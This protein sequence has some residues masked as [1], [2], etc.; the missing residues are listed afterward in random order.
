MNNINR[1][2]HHFAAVPLK[3]TA[4]LRGGSMLVLAL[5]CTLSV[6]Q[7]SANPPPSAR[8]SLADCLEGATKNAPRG[9][10]REFLQQQ[11]AL[12]ERNIRT[13]WFPALDLNGKASYQSDVVTLE[14]DNPQFPLSLPEMP[15]DQY[16]I[17]LDVRQTLYDGGLTKLSG[18]YEQQKTAAEIQQV[19]V[20]TYSIRDQVS[21]LYFAI[22]TAQEN[23]NNLE[24]TLSN[25]K[26]REAALIA[27]LEH[28]A[29]M[30]KDLKVIRVEILKIL[31]ALSD[32]D[33]SKN[34]ALEMLSVYTGLTITTDITLEKPF[35]EMDAEGQGR[36]PEL[37][38]FDLRE[39]TLLTAKELSGAKR[40]PVV[41]AFGQAGY[42]RPGYNMLSTEFD[43]Y[44]MVGAGLKWKIWDWNNTQREQQI[45]DLNSQMVGTAR[46]SFNMNLDAAA[47]KELE[48]MKQLKS[49]IELDD[50]ILQMQMEITSDAASQLENG[51][52]SATD[53][54]HEL[55][56]ESV[57][58]VRRT[59]HE[60]RL[61]Q[62]IAKYNFYHGT[63]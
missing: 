51:V 48:T 55:N 3:L 24:I 35:L 20:E 27:A 13:N 18:Q 4:I 34:G 6:A 53:Y 15:H 22:L 30:E 31:Q 7:Q 21:N 63:L 52:I 45:I 49:S 29:A 17:T 56:N 26:A 36:R 38:L 2:I 14:F 32:I 50:K 58:R 41:F 44:Y 59:L 54:M 46:E 43:T 57:A 10:D 5:T 47:A 9:K 40:R 16:S 12:V 42:G 11:Q 37:G 60:I 61:I 1:M 39:Q 23:R 28:G 19:E 8:L 62:S 25:L 33:A